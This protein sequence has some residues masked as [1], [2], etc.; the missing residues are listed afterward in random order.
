MA[1][2][3]RLRDRRS[4]GPRARDE[5]GSGIGRPSPPWSRRYTAS[6]AVRPRG[7]GYNGHEGSSTHRLPGQPLE[8]QL[9]RRLLLVGSG[10]GFLALSPG[11]PLS[12]RGL[13]A[14]AAARRPP[15]GRSGTVPPH[16]PR[17]GTHQGSARPGEPADPCGKVTGFLRF[18]R[19]IVRRRPGSGA[20]CPLPHASAGADRERCARPPR[21]APRDFLGLV[22]PRSS[23]LWRRA[24]TRALPA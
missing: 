14:H 22:G 24:G 8:A 5:R 3:R 4:P 23:R 1:R 17:I 6:C 20:M 11:R 21:P 13:S 16:P 10:A 7:P 9:K 12:R 18:L 2:L 15:A 19:A